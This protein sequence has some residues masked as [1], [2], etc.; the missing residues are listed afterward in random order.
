[1]FVL[2][3]LG[4]FQASGRV[5]AVSAVEAAARRG[6]ATPTPAPATPRGYLCRL[7]VAHCWRVWSNASSLLAGVDT[8]VHLLASRR[9]VPPA[10]R[11]AAGSF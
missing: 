7:Y 2:V 6:I 10:Y 4:L 9:R 3:L 8:Q 5:G 11:R 1:M